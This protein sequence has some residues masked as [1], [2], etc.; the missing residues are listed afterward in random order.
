MW[1]V[2]G[3]LPLVPYIVRQLATNFQALG[4]YIVVSRGWRVKCLGGT[5]GVWARTPSMCTLVVCGG[6]ILCCL[7]PY[8]SSALD[9]L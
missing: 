3:V 7:P 1:R 8:F 2:C 4:S 9:W 6:D 5:V